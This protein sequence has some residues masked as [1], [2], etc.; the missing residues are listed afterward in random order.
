MSI[1]LMRSVFSGRRVQPFDFSERDSA[2]PKYIARLLWK[3]RGDHHDQIIHRVH[4]T[5]GLVQDEEAS[6]VRWSGQ[7]SNISERRALLDHRNRSRVLG[8]GV[9]C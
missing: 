6:E 2:T 5:K 3:R 1:T 8:G 4:S 7:Q 9:D